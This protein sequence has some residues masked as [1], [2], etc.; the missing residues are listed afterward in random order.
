MSTIRVMQ[1]DEPV[2]AIVRAADPEDAVILAADPD[3]NTTS[4]VVHFDEVWLMMPEPNETPV[5]Y[6]RRVEQARLLAQ[7]VVNRMEAITG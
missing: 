5:A 7:R 3:E 2:P 4:I 1:D 6:A